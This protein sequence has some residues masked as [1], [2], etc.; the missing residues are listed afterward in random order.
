MSVWNKPIIIMHQNHKQQYMENTSLD[1]V[2][3]SSFTYTD[4]FHSCVPS[5]EFT[6]LIDE[7]GPIWSH[8]VKI[9]VTYVFTVLLNIIKRIIN[10]V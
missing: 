5:A 1:G 3:F 10:Y 7:R 9:P 4:M 2:C 6:L 8:F